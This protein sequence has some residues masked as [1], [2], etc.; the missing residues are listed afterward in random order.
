MNGKPP[1][2]PA[3][4]HRHTEVKT[5]VLLQR[6]GVPY[7]VEQKVCP[8]CRRILDERPLRRAAA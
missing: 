8:D 3:R 2:Q 5:H 4:D 6:G 7:E 1:L